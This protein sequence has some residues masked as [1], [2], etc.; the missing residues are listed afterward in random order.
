MPP[1]F[2]LNTSLADLYQYKLARLGETLSQKLA[3]AI[4]AEFRKPDYRSATVEDLLA[5]LPMRYED[6][7]RPAH[8]SELADGMSASLELMV[9]IAGAFQVKNRRAPARSS[10]FIFEITATDPERTGRPIVVW[11]FVSGTHAHD[12]IDYYKKRFTRGARFITFGRWEWDKRRATFSLKLNKPADELEMLPKLETTG[13]VPA[14]SAEPEETAEIETGDNGDPSLSAIHSGRRVPIYRKLGEFSSKRVREI[15]HSVLALLPDVAISE[16]LP[17]ELRQR[18]KLIGRAEALRQI[19]FPAEETPLALYDQARSPAHLRLIFED[20]FWVALGISLKRGKR[21]KETKGAV[22]KLDQATKV[23]IGSVLPFK[24]T[25]A[26]RRVVKEIFKD[27]KSTAPMNRLLQ[28]D[29]GSGK[30]IVALI[31]MLATMESGYQTAL[32]AP[33]EILAEQHARNIKRLLAKSP[34]RVELLTGSLRGAEKRKLQVELAAG[35]IHA[36]VGTHALI[37]ESVSFK[38]LGLAV[39]DEQHRFGV[40]QR[41]ELRARCFNPDVLVMTATPI[42]R[43]LTMTIYGDL[44]VS[45]IDEMPPGRTPIETRVYGEEQ[46]PEVKKLISTEV[47]AGRQVYVVYPLV[48]ESEKIDLK[49]ATRRYEYLRDQVFTKF[50][51]GLVHGKL[52]AAEKEAV[53]RQFVAGE[54]QILVSTT[55]IEVGVDV[56]NASVM[57]VEHAE[58]FG[59]SQLHQL[60]GRVGRGAEKSYCL[61]LTSDKQTVVANERLGIMAQ[62]NDGFVIAE[63]DLEL[64]GPGELLGTR[65]SGLPEFRVANIVRDQQFL[66]GARKEADFYLAKGEQSVETAKLIQRVRADARFGLAVVG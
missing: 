12:I 52:K 65:Q 35:E 14:V 33:T 29:V 31:A 19:H 11:W 32:M 22:I 54:I 10:L 60:R 4:A 43:S 20:F 2:S 49:D 47:R 45:I 28:G 42:P 17:A 41:A 39:I 63:K 40:M 48:E 5:Y 25:D 15:I 57:I 51:V 58:R 64:R 8:I 38:H 6:R 34:Y 55:V 24:L 36:C 50:S 27:L 7:S 16:T 1:P 61:L 53:M 44:D 26:Q 21:T 3:R 66:E 59:L 23:R 37:Q 9:K 30:T 13:D 56:P 18:R 46:R 62:T